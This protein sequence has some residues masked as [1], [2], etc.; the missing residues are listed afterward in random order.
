MSVE[1]LIYNKQIVFINITEYY[2][3]LEINI[4]PAPKHLVNNAAMVQLMTRVIQAFE[5]DN[6]MV[7]ME[8]F[9]TPLGLVMGE[10]AVRPPGGYLMEAIEQAY[11]FNPWQAL[12]AINLQQMPI[13]NAIAKKHVAVWVFHPG[14]GKITEITGLE[15]L[16]QLKSFQ[17]IYLKKKVGDYINARTGTG[18]DVAKLV[19]ANQDYHALTQDLERA[20]SVFRVLLTAPK[21]TVIT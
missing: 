8:F 5:L 9:K 10:F 18:E 16:K 13:V 2:T 3:T 1:I 21:P 19:F 20:R 4:V 7:H 17:S 12:I 15:E 11:G 14:A 6:T